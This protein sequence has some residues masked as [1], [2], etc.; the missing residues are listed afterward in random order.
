MLLHLIFFFLSK[1]FVLGQLLLQG[2]SSWIP[3]THLSH[4][5]PS[6][7]SIIHL[8]KLETDMHAWLWTRLQ[9]LFGSTCLH[10]PLSPSQDPIQ[11]PHCLCL[12][13]TVSPSFSFITKGKS[14]NSM[15]L[16]WQSSGTLRN[17]PM[18][19]FVPLC[20]LWLDQDYDL[21]RG[22]QVTQW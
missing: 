18:P 1:T 19:G 20:V 12:S 16:T 2:E 5:L 6:C 9:T 17:V 22:S 10:S 11:G 21:C 13:G 3:P 7:I 4:H 15:I 14:S 8:S